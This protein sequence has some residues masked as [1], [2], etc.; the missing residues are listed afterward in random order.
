MN[1][2]SNGSVAT[3][4]PNNANYT[5]TDENAQQIKQFFDLI[6]PNG[7]ESTYLCHFTNGCTSLWNAKARINELIKRH[8]DKDIYFGV[9]TASQM[10]NERQRVKLTGPIFPH[11]IAVFFA[12]FDASDYDA[13]LKEAKEKGTQYDPSYGKSLAW[14][15][16]DAAQAD[17]VPA[18]IIVD[19]GGGY[20]GYWLLDRPLTITDENR[21]DISNLMARLVN[22]WK[23]DKAVKDLARVLRVPNSYNH[24]PHYANGP[25]LCKIV[26]LNKSI[27]YDLLQI[28]ALVKPAQRKLTEQYNNQSKK[29]AKIQPVKDWAYELLVAKQCFDSLDPDS[30][31]WYSIVLAMAGTFAGSPVEQQLVKALDEWSA[32]GQKYNEA[33]EGGNAYLIRRWQE[34]KERQE[35]KTGTATIATVINLAK[36]SNKTYDIELKARLGQSLTESI[37]EI[38]NPEELTDMLPDLLQ[39][40]LKLSV[41]ELTQFC[42]DLAKKGVKKGD[43][44]QFRA[45]LKA[46]KKEKGTLPKGEL[47]IAGRIVK[48]G[49]E[50]MAE[51]F[52]LGLDFRMNQLDDSIEAN[53]ERLTDGKIAKIEIEMDDLG[54]SNA[55]KVEKTYTAYAF[56]NQYHPIKDYL[57]A[58]TWDGKDHIK[59]L[60]DH[61]YSDVPEQVEHLFYNG[62]FDNDDGQLYT[63]QHAALR[64]WLAGAVAKVWQAS[65]NTMIVLDGP[66]GIGKSYLSQWLASPMKDYFL[67]SAI[68]TEDKDSLIR[69]AQNWIWEVAELGATTRKSDREAL[70]SLL[71][72]DK[73]V[74]RKA[75]A[76]TDMRKP[77]LAS[78]FGT[79]NNEAGFLGDPTG[80]R[81]FM[82]VPLTD[83]EQS[84]SH[85]LD[86]NQI[87]A[88]AMSLFKAGET[89]NLSQR[90]KEIQTAINLAYTTQTATSDILD[91]LYMITHHPNDKA[92]VTEVQKVLRADGFSGGSAQ[93]KREIDRWMTLNHIRRGKRGTRFYGKQKSCYVGIRYKGERCQ[94]CGQ[95]ESLGELSI[96]MLPR[97]GETIA[98]M[99]CFKCR[100]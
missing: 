57:K 65:Q 64:R 28:Q 23:S 47:T 17:T 96:R 49:H 75:Y 54:Y 69:L 48:Q 91:D 80:N 92:P 85:S 11:K 52:A 66:Q 53:G 13:K 1:K 42:R 93:A 73:V 98:L 56:D 44:G 89:G 15:A 94:Q 3:A 29:K 30:D 86:P 51:L 45:D 74:A 6:W 88:Q 14:Q 60:A 82:V 8:T 50:I 63:W 95:P 22:R 32:R 36:A 76:R 21:A 68:N 59:A 10:G 67:E 38:T 46:I 72:L 40:A 37:K 55:R 26:K 81:R 84:Y 5:I 25:L 35:W 24:K 100:G 41:K 18:S 12:D 90:E 43:I 31:E 78:F 77:A 9:A 16:L 7:E 58:L 79:I 83:I 20:H 4:T 70:K 97:G 34:I 71:T 27:F 33:S 61:L 62:T 19:S 2:E 39:P 87:W 99:I